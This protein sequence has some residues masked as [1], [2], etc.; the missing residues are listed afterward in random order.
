MKNVK[1][2]LTEQR[3]PNTDDSVRAI[4]QEAVSAWLGRELAR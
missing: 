3:Q 1:I 2:I 4:I